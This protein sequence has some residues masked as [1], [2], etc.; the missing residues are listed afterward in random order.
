MKYIVYKTTCSVNNKI[1]IGVHGTEDPD[2]FDGYIGDGI[3]SYFQYYIK[4]PK[5]PFHFAVAKYGFENFTRETLFIYDSEE[6]AY[7]KESE[8]V[9]IEFI[10]KDNN[11]NV[12]LGGQYIKKLS[13]PIYQFSLDGKFIQKFDNA[14]E[15][16]NSTGINPSTIRYSAREKVARLGYLWSWNEDINPEEYYI[17]SYKVYYIYDLDGFYV[18]CFD[19]VSDCANFL[20]QKDY[21]NISR[22]LK[23]GYKVNGY[24]VTDQ[25]LD[26]IRI[27]VT[28][29]NGQLNRY[30]TN[31]DYLDSFDTAAEAKKKLNLK[32]ANLSAAIKKRGLC[33]GYYWTRTDK[34]E[35][36]INVKKK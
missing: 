16:G 18:T 1:Y 9:N 3:S 7:N 27:Q 17:K 24:F 2:I 28:K 14:K 33:N 4:H 22:A 15:A 25:K 10:S 36:H 5:W 31:G 26:Y 11:Y 20:M 30:S 21:A 29:N 34:P 32:L 23:C 8:L 35:K 12:A 19:N 6:D 13:A